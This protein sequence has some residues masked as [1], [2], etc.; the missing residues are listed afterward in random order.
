MKDN[1]ILIISSQSPVGFCSH[2]RNKIKQK[3]KTL[4][5]AYS[6][7]NLRLGEAIECYLNPDR[8]IIGT[9]NKKTEK[10]CYAL[11]EE[12]TDKILTMNIESSEMVKH[13]INAFLAMSIVF[14]DNLADL[15]EETGADISDVVSGLKSDPRIGN[16]SY[17]SPGI[18]FSGGTLGRDLKV[19][20]EVNEKVSNSTG[21][22]GCIH[23]YNSRRKNTI[24]NKISKL[25]AGL[26]GMTIGVLGLT[27][28]PGTS[29]LRRS[30]PLE[31]VNQ[32]VEKSANVRVYDPKADYSE[33]S[34]E[35]K[36]IIVKSIRELSINADILVLLTE[37]PQFKKFDW[38]TVRDSMKTPIIFDA[39]N[40]LIREVLKE[41]GFNYYSIGR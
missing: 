7:E 20:D 22:F 5:L 6:P 13:G 9:S 35:P 38:P 23:E 21:W 4:E 19:L 2:L 29:T 1:S 33:L 37:W 17:L 18:G 31:I 36:F 28:K 24:V 26:A 3:N 12:I 11:F 39:K 25:S 34:F 10:K 30:L 27:Y 14:A 41:S 15:C 16:K 32:L 8:I 40:F